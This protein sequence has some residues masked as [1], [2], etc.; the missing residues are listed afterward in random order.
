MTTSKPT[1]KDK[2]PTEEARHPF[3]PRPIGAV[4][5]SV[6]RPAF[7]KQSPTAAQLMADWPSI[8]GPALAESAQPRR[9]QAGTLTLGC[10]GPVA[11]ELQH[12]AG[13]LIERMNRHLGRDLVQRLRFVQQ[14]TPPPP[15]PPPRRKRAAPVPIDGL[16][17]GPLRDALG[18]LGAAVADDPS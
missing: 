2:P 16:P 13:P 4:M 18:A 1:G 15:A 8:V 14:V 9:F 5:P 7:R 12:L 6:T 11:L 3:G 10:A 17:D